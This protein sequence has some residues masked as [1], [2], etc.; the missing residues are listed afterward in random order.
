MAEFL[1]AFFNHS[2]SHMR[3][4]AQFWALMFVAMAGCAAIGEL[5]KSYGLSR[6]AEHVVR[7]V[8][9]K[10]FEAMV[11]QPISWH[12]APE[13]AAGA[14][15]SR[16]AQDT[17][18]VRA[19]VGQRIALSVAMVVIVV[20]GLGIS[21]DASWRLT[22]VTLGIIPLIVAPIAVTGAYVAKVA[23]AAQES[24]VKA[25]GIA[26][27]A[28][29]HMRTVRAYGIEA[30]ISRRFDDFLELPE[31]QA[32][33]K[34]L[35]GGLGAGVA[36]ATILLG[37]SFQY[38]VG[39]IFF[40]KGWVSFSDLMTV[41]LVI[42]FMAFGIGAVAGDSIDKAEAMTAAKKA[43]DVVHLKSSI[44]ALAPSGYD[45]GKGGAAATVSFEDVAF[46][47]PTRADRPVYERLTFSIAA[48]EV[49]ALVGE[50]GSG[51][52]TAVQLLLRYYDVGGGRISVDGTDVRS[53]D[54]T[55]LRG[56]IGLVSQ[57]PALFTGSIADNIK[58]GKPDASL[59]DVRHAASLANALQF[60]DALPEGFDTQVGSRGIQLSGGQKQRVA[61]ARAIVR[62]P[63][64]LILDEATS[65]LDAKSEQVVQ[66][67]LDKLVAASS[68]TTLVI[69]HRLSTIRSASKICVFGKGGLLEEG[70]H[71]ALLA[72]KSHY[73]ALVA[74]Q[75]A[76]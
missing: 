58:Y 19:L 27:E 52:S 5:W 30:A 70:T 10:S 51:K 42:I 65:A 37:A 12:D 57:E 34:G 23:E 24:L 7:D 2:T 76:K 1:V 53:W 44:D 40:R 8:R 55:A 62:K 54:V 36:A 47:Y 11:R 4:E 9:T 6:A 28:V 61:I 63:R 66:A 49:C 32:I 15:A 13:R 73:Y 69:A 20:G 50:S 64:L 67:A 39:G 45:G 56:S 17:Q 59:E 16:L 29:L 25:G 18:A 74:H 60:I 31:R 33:R 43:W 68:C 22:L 35:A 46:A 71:D 72:K 38:Y 75:M 3:R 48:G 26:T 21:F 41:L 14:L